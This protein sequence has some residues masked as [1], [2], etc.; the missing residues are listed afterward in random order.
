MAEL[1][2]PSQ[3]KQLKEEQAATGA[4]VNELEAKNEGLEQ[5]SRGLATAIGIRRLR[6]STAVAPFDRK[7]RS[8]P[9][10]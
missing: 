6:H 1:D 5:V 10:C 4:R 9:R 7:T 2:L 8:T 3:I